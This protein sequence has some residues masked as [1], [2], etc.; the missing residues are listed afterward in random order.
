LNTFWPPPSPLADLIV[1]EG[2]V[3]V[4]WLT[5]NNLP[6]VVATMGADCSSEQAELIVSLVKPTGRIWV[7]SDGDAAGERHALMVFALVGKKRFVRWIQT[8]ENKQPTDYPGAFFRE[9]I[10]I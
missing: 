6:N 2:F 3:S 10:G 8:A 5:Q 4:W 1:V 9:Q 7:I